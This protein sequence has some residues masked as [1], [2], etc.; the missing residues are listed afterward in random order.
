MPPRFG[1]LDPLRALSLSDQILHLADDVAAL[2]VD[3]DQ[4]LLELDVGPRSSQ[5]ACVHEVD[6]NVYQG[7]R[8]V[9]DLSLDID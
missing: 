1:Q 3:V 5:T 4:N 7:E 2:H 8:M 6:R 9:I